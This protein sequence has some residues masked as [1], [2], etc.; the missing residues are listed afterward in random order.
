MKA[1]L[2]VGFFVSLAHAEQFE[3][4]VPK[5]AGLRLFQKLKDDQ[6]VERDVLVV[7]QQVPAGSKLSIT[8]DN[9]L[10]FQWV[11]KMVNG[12]QKI[13]QHS[14]PIF[15]SKIIYLPPEADQKL[16][17]GTFYVSIRDMDS[18]PIVSHIFNE[19]LPRGAEKVPYRFS[20][21][22]HNP[23]GTW[24]YA[25][26][27]GLRAN[28]ALVS[29]S[30]RDVADFCP[31]YFSLAKKEKEIFWI[32]LVNLI[33]N[34][35]SSYIPLTASDEGRFNPGAKGVISSGLTQLSLGSTRNACYQARGCD[36]IRNQQD[37]FTP[38]R[39]LRCAIAVMSCL[40]E[41]GGCVSCKEGNSW[42][43]IAAYWSTLRT[44]YTLNCP[45]CEGG[46]VTVGKKALIQEM[47][48]AAAPFCF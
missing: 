45:T 26:R 18:V 6:G 19:P 34:F 38:A 4:T 22:A 41:S 27:E 32:A 13:I 1:L 47:A 37:L 40:A 39:E 3:V 15:I 9:P 17:Q 31:R 24:A 5:Q 36:L 12:V 48:K 23:K 16:L 43:G 20:W 29:D 11:P 8:V 2:L 35:E 25:V 14:A 46:K 30:P 42:K 28:E 10:Q 33:A 7:Q 21:D 44:P